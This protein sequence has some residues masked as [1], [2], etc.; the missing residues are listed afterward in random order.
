MFA[1]KPS[2]EEVLDSN[3]RAFFGNERFLQY[4][5]KFEYVKKLD[6]KM[7]LIEERSEESLE[8]DTDII[9]LSD[10]LDVESNSG[11]DKRNGG[12]MSQSSM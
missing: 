8:S 9:I 6:S 5:G 3:L 4:S 2:N 10:L 1:L 11:L 12:T 7:S